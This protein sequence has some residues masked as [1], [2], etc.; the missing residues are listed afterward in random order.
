MVGVPIPLSPMQHLYARTKP[1]PE[2]AGRTEEISEPFVRHQDRA[3]YFRQHGEAY[4]MGSYRHE[5]LL[6][7]SED[8]LD[9]EDAPVAPAEMAFTPSHFESARASAGE[10]MPALKGAELDYK[11]NG[12]FSFTTDG[13]PVLGESPQVKGFWSAQAVWITHAGGVGKAVAE[14]MVDGKPGVDLRECDITRFHP[15]AYSR[16][17][18]RARSAQQYR[19]VYDNHPPASAA[20]EGQGPTAQPLL[21]ASEGAGRRLLRERGMGAAAVVRGQRVSAG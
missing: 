1:L 18:V 8:I 12:M 6:V 16:E 20:V 2:L 10:L 3:M 19:E 15:H 11:I 7:D 14:W 17:F 5:P 21:A 13:F 4:G 9:H